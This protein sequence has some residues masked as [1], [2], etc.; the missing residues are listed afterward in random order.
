MFA[1]K[2]PPPPPDWEPP[3]FKT[4][5]LP[6]IRQSIIVSVTA[7][8]L[9]DAIRVASILDRAIKDSGLEAECVGFQS[10]PST[11]EDNPLVVIIPRKVT[12]LMDVIEHNSMKEKA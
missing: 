11:I 4:L 9:E 3:E 2:F 10:A 8:T 7:G 12:P 5:E 1:P 6:K